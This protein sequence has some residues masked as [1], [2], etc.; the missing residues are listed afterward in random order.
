MGISIS[1]L[2]E[3]A[4]YV[5]LMKHSIISATYGVGHAKDVVRSICADKHFISKVEKCY[6]TLRE[7]IKTLNNE[8]ED[9]R[10][11]IEEKVVED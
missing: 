7:L 8:Y 6:S 1:T 9:I 3:R 5:L 4:E 11:S 10:K 2:L